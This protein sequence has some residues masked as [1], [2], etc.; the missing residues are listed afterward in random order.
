VVVQPVSVENI[1]P[2]SVLDLS[3]RPQKRLK[4]FTSRDMEVKRVNANLS[5][6]WGAL[7]RKYDINPIEI[8]ASVYDQASADDLGLAS[9]ASAAGMR[10]CKY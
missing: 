5:A 10:H 1:Y 2:R 4:A 3:E 8:D 9:R 7:N 6:F